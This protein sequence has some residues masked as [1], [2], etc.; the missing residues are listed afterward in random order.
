MIKEFGGSYLSPAYVEVELSE[1]ASG[2]GVPVGAL[3]KRT[4]SG[5]EFITSDAPSPISVGGIVV[6]TINRGGGV[7]SCTILV[8]GVWNGVAYEWDTTSGDWRTTT[9]H[10]TGV[11][12]TPVYIV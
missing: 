10:K 5:F 11:L 12:Q 2:K 1:P 7:Y 4:A 8:V 6:S 3:V 9:R